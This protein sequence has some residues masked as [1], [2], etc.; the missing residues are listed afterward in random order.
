ME[1][2]CGDSSL[3]VVA[4]TLG[5]ACTLCAPTFGSGQEV[6]F[7][8]SRPDPGRNAREQDGIRTGRNGT[9]LGTWMGPKHCKTKHMANLDGTTS[10]PGWDLDGPRIGPRRGS[11][12]HSLRDSN[13]LLGLSDTSPPPRIERFS[14]NPFVRIDSRESGRFALRIA[15]TSKTQSG[16]ARVRLADLNGPKWTFSGQN[17]P[18]ASRDQNGPFWSILVS[19]ML[20]SSSE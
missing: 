2:T 15:G 12:W 16:M 19:R 5:Y 7:C 20:K 11:G 14:A 18:Q 10:N 9:H 1:R 13:R 8:P 6:C 3:L 17:G 4:H